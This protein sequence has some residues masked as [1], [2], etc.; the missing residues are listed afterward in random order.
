MA[1]VHDRATRSRNMRAIKNKNTKP[2]MLIRKALHREGFRYK[3]HQ[4]DLPGKPDLVFPKYHA[5]IQVHGCFWHAH[6][7]HLSKIPDTD[8]ARWRAKLESNKE[9]DTRNRNKLLTMGWRVCEVWE[10]SL[11]GKNKRA[12][13]LVVDTIRNWLNSDSRHMEISGEQKNDGVSEGNF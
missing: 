4:T 5:V 11:K 12:L 1:D 3:L 8:E 13:L 7:C 10:C 6:G 2:E 9:R